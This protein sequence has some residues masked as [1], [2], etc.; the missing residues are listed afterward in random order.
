[1]KAIRLRLFPPEKKIL[2][3]GPPYFLP[4]VVE[5]GSPFFFC[6]AQPSQFFLFFPLLPL[7]NR[8]R[9]FFSPAAGGCG[10]RAE[11]FDFTAVVSPPLLGPKIHARKFGLV[12]FFF[13]VISG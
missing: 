10:S 13:S 4:H 9:F 11:N 6:S 3:G 1:M 5:E 7:G 8:W 12:F 2:L